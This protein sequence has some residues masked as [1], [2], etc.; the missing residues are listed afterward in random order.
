MVVMMMIVDWVKWGRGERGI[1]VELKGVCVEFRKTEIC[2][3]ELSDTFR[4]LKLDLIIGKREN[5]E[6]DIIFAGRKNKNRERIFSRSK[7]SRF[8]RFSTTKK[9]LDSWLEIFSSFP[10]HE[11]KDNNENLSPFVRK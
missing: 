3:A 4:K 2:W 9:F 11:K 10:I 7:N 8:V 6:I 1:S 5:T